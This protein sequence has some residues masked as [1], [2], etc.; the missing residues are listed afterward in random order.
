MTRVVISHAGE[1]TECR[2]LAGAPPPPCDL[3]TLVCVEFGN[4]TTAY[5][6]STLLKKTSATRGGSKLKSDPSECCSF[7]QKAG[8]QGNK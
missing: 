7:E 3:G 5:L 1:T 8:A 4:L 6:R 2:I